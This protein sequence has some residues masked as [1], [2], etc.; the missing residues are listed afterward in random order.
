MKTRKNIIIA[1]LAASVAIGMLSGCA[2][3]AESTG[4]PSSGSRQE[5]SPS[6]QPTLDGHDPESM[7]RKT[8]SHFLSVAAE[9]LK[10]VSLA[11]VDWSDASLGCPQPGMNY[12]QVITPGYDA[13]FV[14][15]RHAYHVH[16]A[17]G[18][19]LVCKNPSD[20]IGYEIPP[21]S[22]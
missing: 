1:A 12:A 10:L 7:A 13:V 8:L 11:A 18:R 5:R 9:D 15:D 17:N 20:G 4:E 16:M 19:V 14:H 2:V 21:R 22:E 6:S 3:D